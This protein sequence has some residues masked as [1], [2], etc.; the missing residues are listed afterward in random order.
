[1]VRIKI[2]TKLGVALEDMFKDLGAS[3][4]VV[5]HT[6]ARYI[7]ALLELLDGYEQDPEE[8]LKTFDPP[9]QGVVVYETCEFYSLCE[10]HML[11]FFGRVH[12]GYR[13]RTKCIGL[14]KLAR[15]VDVY[16]HRLQIQERLTQQIADALFKG[17][18]PAYDPYCGVYV[19]VEGRHLCMMMRGIK[20]Q[21]TVTITEQ[22]RGEYLIGK[23]AHRLREEFKMILR[24]KKVKI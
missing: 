20:K 3:T 23:D 14:S 1:M 11:P 16:A 5:E 8:V 9:K 12:I 13:S 19:I 24:E 21:D 2:P 7:N 18:K 4:E 10:H 22:Y 17:L 15:L 6:P